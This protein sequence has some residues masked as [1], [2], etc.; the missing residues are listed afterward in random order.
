MSS[1]S[2]GLFAGFSV[3]Q[4][5]SQPASCFL[6]SS[7]SSVRKRMRPLRRTLSGRLSILR[8]SRDEITIVFQVRAGVSSHLRTTNGTK[9]HEGKQRPRY[10]YCTASGLAIFRVF[11][12]TWQG[13]EPAALEDF[14]ELALESFVDQAIAGE[15]FAALDLER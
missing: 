11:H 14:L 12:G 8:S 1:R 9:V 4:G 10:V 5:R 3:S 2:L 7:G 13:L 15:R 6:M